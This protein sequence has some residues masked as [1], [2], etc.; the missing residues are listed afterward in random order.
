MIVKI[1]SS[2]THIFL[3]IPWLKMS[4]FVWCLLKNKFLTKDNL[5]HCSIINCR[6]INYVGVCVKNERSTYILV[7]CVVFGKMWV[8]FFKWLGISFFLNMWLGIS[9]LLHNQFIYTLFNSMD[10][11]E[12]GGSFVLYYM[13][14]GWLVPIVFGGSFVLYYMVFGHEESTI[15]QLIDLHYFSYDLNQWQLNPL[16]CYTSFDL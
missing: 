8:E 9:Y 11:L 4:L 7:D 3:L 12:V 5:A 2:N 1:I 6:L 15:L 16:R 14:F 13:Y 10:F